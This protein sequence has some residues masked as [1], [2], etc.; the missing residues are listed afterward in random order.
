MRV[1]SLGA[2]DVV[3][4]AA[5]DRSETVDVEYEVIDGRLTERPVSMSEVSAWDPVGDGSH[6]VA[7]AIRFCA[8]RVAEGGV[9]LGVFDD[10]RLLGLAIVN[11]AFEGPLAWLAWLHVNRADRRRG[12]AR[13]LWAEAV[14]R[15]RDAGSTAIYVSATPTGSAVGFYLDRGCRLADPVHPDLYADEPDDVHLVCELA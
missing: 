15:A 5:I 12:V 4:V 7:A 14:A 6:S 11:P 8:E 1:R 9:L 2:A 3:L 10:D 13:A